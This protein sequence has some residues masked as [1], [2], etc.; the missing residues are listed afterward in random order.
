MAKAKRQ[1]LLNGGAPKSVATSGT[2]SAGSAAATVAAAAQR[3]RK[4][5]DLSNSTTYMLMVVVSVFLLVELPMAF[6]ILIH[7]L[8][9]TGVL[10]FEGDSHLHYLKLVVILCNFVIMLSFPVNFAIYTKMS[11][12]FRNTL[13]VMFQA[14]PGLAR[15]V[16][17]G[18]A[19]N[20]N[21]GEPATTRTT[22]PA[23]RAAGVADGPKQS[24]QLAE[25][26]PN[27]LGH[28]GHQTT[29]VP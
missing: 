14:V 20:D 21:E 27:Q 2:T 1:K 28:N 11:T 3:K 29:L 7:L 26:N 17:G 10:M 24:T 4:R 9:N 22:V 19:E 15:L 8:A 25:L 12:P 16:G 13:V 23:A 6:A 18:D 5:N